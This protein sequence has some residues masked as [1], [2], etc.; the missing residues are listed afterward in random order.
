MRKTAN[1]LSTYTTTRIAIT[2]SVKTL[3]PNLRPDT[4]HLSATVHQEE[5]ATKRARLP[6]ANAMTWYANRPGT[7]LNK[8]AAPT[9]LQP[10]PSARLTPKPWPSERL[11]PNKTAR[12][13]RA[14]PK[15]ASNLH[16]RLA[17]QP[18]PQR[19]HRRMKQPKLPCPQPSAMLRR[20]FNPGAR[21]RARNAKPQF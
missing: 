20:T 11:T 4:S 16:R 14:G 9:K 5:P 8:G 1:S 3:T 13:L 12:T 6:G 7:G 19:Q 17:Q 21:P 15:Q 2:A 18:Q 10:W